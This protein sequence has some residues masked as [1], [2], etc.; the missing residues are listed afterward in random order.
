MI[1]DKDKHIETLLDN[2]KRMGNPAEDKEIINRLKLKLKKLAED[3]DQLRKKELEK[4]EK[5]VKAER[6]VVELEQDI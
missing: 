4:H 3:N 5:L 1:V 6:K 2:T